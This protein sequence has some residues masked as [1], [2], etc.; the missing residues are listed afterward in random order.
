MGLK[1]F[2]L[3]VCAVLDFE[4]ENFDYIFVVLGKFIY[5]GRDWLVVHLRI[6]WVPGRDKRHAVN[7]YLL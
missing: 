6:G 4:A 2:D 1:G 7:I 5:L 3:L